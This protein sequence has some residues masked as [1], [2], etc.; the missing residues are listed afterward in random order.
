MVYIGNAF[1][2]QMIDTDTTHNVTIKPL[3]IPE[4]DTILYDREFISCIGHPDTASVVD[5]MLEKTI[6][7]NRVSVKLTEDDVLIVAQLVG[8]RL[9]EGATRVPEGFEL[10]FLHV[11]LK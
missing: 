7:C 10:K 1:S 4:V 6:P 2:L 5:S 9:P 3:T 11:S 8:G